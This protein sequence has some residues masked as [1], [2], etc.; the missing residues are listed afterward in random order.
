MKGAP[1]TS[2]LSQGWSVRWFNKWE[3]VLDEALDSLPEH[4]QWP[5]ILLR[6]MFET[7]GSVPKKAALVLDRDTPI[8]LLGLRYRGSSTWEPLPTYIL[9]G[10]LMVGKQELTG[11]VLTKL[12]TSLQV[13]WWRMPMEPPSPT[14]HTVRAFKVLPTHILSVTEDPEVYWRHSHYLDTAR[15]ARRKSAHFRFAVNPPGALR[16]AIDN[17]EA[18]WRGDSASPRADLGD[19]LA[20]DQFLQERG[21]HFVLALLDGEQLIAAEGCVVDNGDLVSLVTYRR[22][23]YNSYDVGH[24]LAIR[25]IDWAKQSGFQRYDIG[26]G[27]FAFKKRFAPAGG[28]KTQ[29][30]I[31]PAIRYRLCQLM[32]YGHTVRAALHLNRLAGWPAVER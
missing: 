23:E 24:A 11:P 26:G 3:R 31:C 9:P 12:P 28:Q 13:A 7:P 27:D 5:N 14:L 22:P 8:A 29:L 17:W 4:P 21:Q 6:I 20:A 16:W 32:G 18:K 2:Q 19:R 15:R 25:I 1:V 10:F 30:H